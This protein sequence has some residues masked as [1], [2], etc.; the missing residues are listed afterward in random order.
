[1]TAEDAY[2]AW[3]IMKNGCTATQDTAYGAAVALPMH[4]NVIGS[5]GAIELMGEKITVRRAPRHSPGATI[6]AAERIRRGLL[7]G[8]ADEVCE[9]PPPAGEA[10]EPALI[11]W[12]EKV[13]EALRTGRQIAPSFD[14]GVAVAEVMDQLRASAAQPD[15]ERTG[16]S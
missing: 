12:L 2:S 3:F 14:D 15:L 10:H 13:K 7:P 16:A 5:E 11:P 6:P 4:I 9:F 1:V 8:Q